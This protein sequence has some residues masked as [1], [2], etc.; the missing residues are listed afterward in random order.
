MPSE[1][2]PGITLEEQGM[3]TAPAGLPCEA[4][5]GCGLC[6]ITNSK[7]DFMGNLDDLSMVPEEQQGKLQVLFKMAGFE[8]KINNW[9]DSVGE[10]GNFSFERF[11]R[12]F[13]G[14]LDKHGNISLTAEIMQKVD[15]TELP[16]I[17]PI[18]T[19]T[20]PTQP[21][22]D[23][24]V[25]TLS[26]P[27]KSTDTQ[28]EILPEPTQ[29]MRDST[30][31]DQKISAQHISEVS[32][33]SSL[34]NAQPV[35]FLHI[36]DD[37]YVRTP[38]RVKDRNARETPATVLPSN[39]EIVSWEKTDEAPQWV[40]KVTSHDDDQNSHVVMD[41]P[42]EILTTT[43]NTEAPSSISVD[44][45]QNNVSAS[46]NFRVPNEVTVV[47]NRAEAQPELASI[48]QTHIEAR[49][50]LFTFIVMLS[51]AEE[52]KSRAFEQPMQQHNMTDVTERSNTTEPVRVP[53]EKHQSVDAL[54]VEIPDQTESVIRQ[55]LIGANVALVDISGVFH[56][57]KNDKTS[58]KTHEEVYAIRDDENIAWQITLIIEPNKTM[59]IKASPQ[60]IK[61]LNKRLQRYLTQDGRERGEKIR[62][63]EEEIQIDLTLTP[64][65]NPSD[66]YVLWLC[67]IFLAEIF[68][69][70]REES[71]TP[72]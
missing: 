11:G 25:K 48:V 67:Y 38:E 45:P 58:F 20:L 30:N 22:S 50:K 4:C 71:H 37:Q 64:F 7:I 3:F 34:E 18:S 16:T 46:E 54:I 56:V 31:T 72:V 2:D 14:T 1:F 52:Q 6:N 49:H 70:K 23:V 36:L 26:S 10:Q 55:Y 68:G 69:I 43:R 29:E 65:V 17:Q 60:A 42:L 51:Q 66:S 12:R 35:E 41:T 44:L 61:L 19:E 40:L 32:P 57:E 59:I 47:V 27:T 62:K 5:S 39:E 13:Q 63:A 28:S 9:D 21:L 15:A 53:H 33:I 8:Q 24:S